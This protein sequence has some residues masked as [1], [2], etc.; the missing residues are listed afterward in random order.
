MAAARDHVDV[1]ELLLSHGAQVNRKTV[2]KMAPLH[3]ATARGFTEMVKILLHAGA[4]IDS[5][6]SSERTALH[7]AVARGHVEVTELLI[8]RGA[9]VNIE[10]I[11]GEILF[12]VVSNNLF[13]VNKP[14]TCRYG[15]M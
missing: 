14:V 6:D 13:N 4:H 15:L 3:F 1:V 10:E 11:H 9:K 7:L 2:D 12:I 8:Q 5:V